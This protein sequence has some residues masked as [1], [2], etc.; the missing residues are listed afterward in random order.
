MCSIRKNIDFPGSR[1]M[2]SK[3]G[4]RKI[5]KCF[6]VSKYF[7]PPKKI[8]A[9]FYFESL[10]FPQVSGFKF[11]FPR[12]AQKPIKNISSRVKNFKIDVK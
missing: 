10:P 8:I 4:G 7:F 2:G 9:E 12:I 5:Q 3:M 11:T 6:L 1:H